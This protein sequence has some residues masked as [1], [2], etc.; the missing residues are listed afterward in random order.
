M[1]FWRFDV[2]KVEEHIENDFLL[3]GRP[4]ARAQ[5]HKTLTRVSKEG[6]RK[7]STTVLIAIL[8]LIQ[9]YINPVRQSDVDALDGRLNTNVHTAPCS[10][11]RGRYACTS[12]D[13]LG[14]L[15]PFAVRIRDTRK[16][17]LLYVQRHDDCR[18]YYALLRDL[19][20]DLD[21]LVSSGSR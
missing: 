6:I 9:Q 13:T 15:Y 14:V 16:S 10:E 8:S 12:L 2:E 17:D 1:P 11:H 7:Q 3:A 18:K 21:R 5:V 20:Q 4:T 19:Y